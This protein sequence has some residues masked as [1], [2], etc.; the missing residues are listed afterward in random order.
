MDIQSFG[1]RRKLTLILVYPGG[2]GLL[3]WAGGCWGGQEGAE[4]GRR[5]LGWAGV[6]RMGLGW[7]GSGPGVVS[8]VGRY[9][10]LAALHHCPCCHHT[11]PPAVLAATTTTTIYHITLPPLPTPTTNTHLHHYLHLPQTPPPPHYQHSYIII[12]IYSD[13]DSSHTHT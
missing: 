1:F 6:G 10:R 9:S 7:A 11:R 13:F 5:G 4:V 3:G 2:Q 8:M 12:N